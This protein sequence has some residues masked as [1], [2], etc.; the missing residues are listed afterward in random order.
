MRRRRIRRIA[1]LLFYE[2]ARPR[3]CSKDRAMRK[4][5]FAGL[6]DERAPRLNPPHA[7]GV[8]AVRKPRGRFAPLAA[9]L[10]A[11]TAN[12]VPWPSYHVA[13]DKIKLPFLYGVFAPFSPRGKAAPIMAA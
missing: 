6:I 2:R 5:R 8:Q 9:T 13:F 11:R 7:V 4:A 12:A 10:Y 1:H 3:V